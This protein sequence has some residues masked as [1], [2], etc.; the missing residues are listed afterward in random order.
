MQQKGFDGASYYDGSSGYTLNT[1][2]ISAHETQTKGPKGAFLDERNPSLKRH[3]SCPIMTTGFVQQN[4]QHQQV[5]GPT[6][7]VETGNANSQSN[8]LQ[9]HIRPDR[10]CEATQGGKGDPLSI[11]AVPHASSPVQHGAVTVMA[12]ITQAGRVVT[13]ETALDLS[14]LVK[15]NESTTPLTMT[16][17]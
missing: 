3:A 5:V 1:R 9:E 7:S 4:D 8:L 17:G 15:N 2:N 14:S 11:Q 10:T 6:L 12:R 16:S 13:H